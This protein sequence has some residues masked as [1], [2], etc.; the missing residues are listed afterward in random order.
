MTHF[1]YVIWID[2]ITT[3]FDRCL[4]PLL[5]DFLDVL[6]AFLAV[7]I[8]IPLVPIPKSILKS[9]GTGARAIFV[10]GY[11]LATVTSGVKCQLIPS[12]G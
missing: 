4:D 1:V 5:H 11:S 7:D 2:S 8:E 3:L 9:F 6:L 10:D 12:I